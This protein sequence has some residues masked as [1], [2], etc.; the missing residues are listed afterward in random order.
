MVDTG[1]GGG[2][3]VA[4]G[5]NTTVGASTSSLVDIDDSLTASTTKTVR[6]A[7]AT[8]FDVWKEMEEVKKVV[9]GK[10]V[11]V[12][13]ICN[14]CKSRLSA[15]STGGTGQLHRHIRACKRKALAASSSS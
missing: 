4:V 9:R 10:E 6:R 12:G 3:A 11:R 14:Y 8:R 1:V 13:A 15:P 2:G 7:R 5:P